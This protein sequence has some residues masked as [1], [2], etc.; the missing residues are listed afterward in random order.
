M[1]WKKA[2]T[3][4]GDQVTNKLA[5]ND[6]AFFLPLL[7]FFFFFCVVF[8]VCLLGFLFDLIRWSCLC[9]RLHIRKEKLFL[10]WE[11]NN[12]GVEWQKEVFVVACFCCS[13][14][15]CSVAFSISAPSCTIV[16]ALS[17]CCT[18]SVMSH[19]FTG[20]VNFEGCLLFIKLWNQ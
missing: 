3:W 19:S 20:I 6:C 15:V 18:D 8:F 9:R 10:F 7:F 12:G 17:A 5:G 16:H 1:V 13:L 2:L 14:L 4:C 11:R